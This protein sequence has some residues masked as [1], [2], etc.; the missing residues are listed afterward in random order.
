[1]IGSNTLIINEA[2]MIQAV[3]YWLDSVMVKAPKVTG[4]T[5]DSY[6]GFKILLVEEEKEND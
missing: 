2:T 1:M 6:I 4:V 5:N 3:Q